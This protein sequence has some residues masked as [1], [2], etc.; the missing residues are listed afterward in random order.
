MI[1]RQEIRPAKVALETRDDFERK[2]PK[3]SKGLVA[4]IKLI[5]RRDTPSEMVTTQEEIVGRLNV[6]SM[7]ELSNAVAACPGAL[8]GAQHRLEQKRQRGL[9]KV[10]T[11]LQEF[12]QTFDQFLKAYSGIVSVVQTADSQYGGLAFGTL[13]LLFAVS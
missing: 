10:G 12:A 3:L 13:S 11:D 6:M 1:C 7:Q 2:L 4:E 5:F 8:A 9:R